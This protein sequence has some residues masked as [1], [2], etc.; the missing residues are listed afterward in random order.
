MLLVHAPVYVILY[1]RLGLASQTIRDP[2]FEVK[3]YLNR[4]IDARSIDQLRSENIHPFTLTFSKHELEIKV[5]NKLISENVTDEHIV[6][7]VYRFL[8]F[9]SGYVFG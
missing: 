5:S 4:A 7:I 6:Y 3:E 8:C 2:D 9:L 1:T